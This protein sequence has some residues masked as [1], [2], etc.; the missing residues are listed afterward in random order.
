[1]HHH[2][3]L[4][5]V[6]WTILIGII[7]GGLG[8]L[9]L[10]GRQPIGFLV[11]IVVGIVASFIGFFIAEGLGVAHTNGINWIEH[12][13]QVVLAAIGVVLVMRLEGRRG[14]V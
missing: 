11:T 14:R 10:P 6:I 12:I 2:L 9:V 1:M 3:T 5:V 8:R 4:A 7:I 13:I